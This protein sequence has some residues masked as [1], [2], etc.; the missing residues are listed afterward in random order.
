MEVSWKDG[1]TDT[2][3]LDIF[4]AEGDMVLHNDSSDANPIEEGFGLKTEKDI[5]P[6]LFFEVLT[7]VEFL[8]RHFHFTPISLQTSPISSNSTFH[9]N[10][11]SSPMM[12]SSINQNDASSTTSGDGD[13]SSGGSKSGRS[14]TTSTSDCQDI[15]REDEQTIRKAKCMIGLSV[16][17][18][19][20][21]VLLS[22]YFLTGHSDQR[23]FELAVS[24]E[25]KRQCIECLPR[26][27][28][29]QHQTTIWNIRS[30]KEW[31]QT[32][33]HL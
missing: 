2:E 20:V 10:F 31:S 25:D 23:S 3:L 24:T 11:W 14:Q 21:A 13:S 9:R 17:I 27:L 29:K 7:L 5:M 16:L 1:G 6:F 33:N 18:C 32:S 12:N 22:V 4:H 30:I 8:S 15:V 28:L 26:L 19:A